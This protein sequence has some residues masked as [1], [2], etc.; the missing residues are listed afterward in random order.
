MS[1]FVLKVPSL[2]RRDGRA[3]L[4]ASLGDGR[5]LKISIEAASELLD[6][7]T[8]SIIPFLPVSFLLA[9]QE[10]RSL[11]VD[12][13]V[14]D[15]WWLSLI[16]SF[17]PLLRRLFEFEKI[18]ITRKG[19]GVLAQPLTRDIALMFSAGV[20]SFYSLK[21]TRDLGISPDWFV[22]INAGA[23]EYNRDC[24]AQRLANVRKAAQEI[25]VGLVAIDTNFHEAFKVAHVH[26]HS[27]RNLPAAFSLFPGIGRFVYSSTN[28]F[29]EISYDTAKK[30]GIH[31]LDHAVYST[32]TPAPLSLNILGCGADRISKT[33]AIA[34]DRIANRFLDVCV[35]E[36]Y[37]AARTAMEPINCGQCSKC[38]RTM[39]TLDHY[40]KL[41]N[42][43]SQFPVK[44]FL[45]QREALIR[46][47]GE[48]DDPLDTAVIK[49]LGRQTPSFRRLLS[50]VKR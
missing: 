35:N 3:E 20:D 33:V 50:L 49:L 42:F 11:H 38:T 18:S 6:R 41:Q 46:T 37:Q 15:S 8:P 34:D 43:E 10:R 9:G 22:N 4:L 28:A 48:R 16:G 24:W 21:T 1:Q 39:L 23:H 2:V 5:E 13:D 25:G 31:Y 26:S 36:K 14:E 19:S 47:L 45:D 40:K 7:L 17:W 29:D 27:V 44:Q 12:A 30:H 32:F